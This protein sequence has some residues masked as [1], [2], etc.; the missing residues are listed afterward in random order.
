LDD[1]LLPDGRRELGERPLRKLVARLEPIRDEAADFH[2]PGACFPW[3]VV[4]TRQERRQASTQGLF[5]SHRIPL[6]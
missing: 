4:A 2:L 6:L 3:N 5:L 1:A